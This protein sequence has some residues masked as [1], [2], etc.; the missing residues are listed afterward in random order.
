MKKVTNW[1]NQQFFVR[2]PKAA[3]VIMLVSVAVGMGVDIYLDASRRTDKHFFL[4]RY[5]RLTEMLF[6]YVVAMAVGGVVLLS[7]SGIYNKWKRRAGR[8]A[9]HESKSIKPT[10]I[11]SKPDIDLGENQSKDE[12]RV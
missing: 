6:R 9:A 7:A 12:R 1:L 11:P 10:N 8:K 5:D 3:I 2:E 4:N